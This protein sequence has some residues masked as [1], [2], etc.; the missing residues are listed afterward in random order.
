MTLRLDIY[1]DIYLL[2]FKLNF[3]ESKL[4]EK[5]YSFLRPSVADPE[6][7]L[8]LAIRAIGK[9]HRT[10]HPHKLATVLS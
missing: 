1:L 9:F 7:D 10:V 4:I 8:V 2:G 6:Y 3:N 5:L